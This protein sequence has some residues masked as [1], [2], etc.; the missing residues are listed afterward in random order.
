MTPP[1]SVADTVTLARPEAPAAVLN[2][3]V[4][5]AGL[6]DTES[7]NEGAEL[8]VMDTSTRLHRFRRLQ[9]NSKANGHI[10]GVVGY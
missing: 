7:N 3:N 1:E 6:I 4:P 9:T 8:L 2:V 5:V 10:D